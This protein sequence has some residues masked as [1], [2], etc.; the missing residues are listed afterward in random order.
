MLQLWSISKLEGLTAALRR[1]ISFYAP[2]LDSLDLM[3]IDAVTYTRA[4]TL[5]VTHRGGARTIPANCPPFEYS[6]ETPLGL[7]IGATATLQFNAVNDLDNANTLMWMQEGTWKSTPTDANPI[8][9]SGAWTG[10]TG[11]HVKHLTKAKR[12][13]SNGEINLIQLG[14]TDI[15]QA[16]PE[17]PPPPAS[18]AGTPIIETPAHLGGGVY[19]AS[20]DIDLDSLSV[21]AHGG[22]TL[23][24]VGAAPGNL[25]FMASGAGN[26]TITPGLAPNPTNNITL[27]YFTA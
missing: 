4:G 14:L 23:T 25:Q 6:G 10:S 21:V 18:S 2:L 19:L 9:G 13:L 3:G 22:L 11:V 5:A 17:V 12:Q 15:V 24:R 8:A 16:I 7:L 20:Q 27:Q 1:E 26:R